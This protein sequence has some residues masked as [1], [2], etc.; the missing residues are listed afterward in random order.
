MSP[1]SSYRSRYS[2]LRLFL[3]SFL[4]VTTLSSL[5]L[6]A[7]AQGTTQTTT[8]TSA[9]GPIA[10]PVLPPPPAANLTGYQNVSYSASSILADGALYIYGG[11][12]K[13][14]DNPLVANIGSNQFLR[15]DLTKNFSTES[16]PWTPL[17]GS[18]TFTMIDSVPSYDGQ[19]M[20]LAGNRDNNGPLAHIY[21]LATKNWITTPN[22]PGMSSMTG[23]KRGNVGAALDPRS[24]L[25]YIYG[26]FAYLGF[27]NEISVLNTAKD[28]AN[29]DWTLSFNQSNVP[30]LYQPFVAYLPTQMKI[31]VFGGCNNYNMDTGLCGGCLPLSEG[32]L[33]DHG[34]KQATLGIQRTDLLN[35]P[36]PR[37]QSCYA[38]LKDGRVLLQGGRDPDTFFGDAWILDPANWTWTKL[39]ISGPAAAM[40]RA[41]HTCDMGPNGQLLIVG[42]FTKVNNISSYVMP[43]MAVIDTV[44]WTWKSDYTGA[45]VDSIWTTLP[46]NDPNEPEPNIPGTL[47]G[48]LPGTSSGLS[49]GA[50]A[51][52][53][54]GVATALLLVGLGVFYWR[55]KKQALSLT[56]DANNDQLANAKSGTEGACGPGLVLG[57]DNDQNIHID[58]LVAR[59]GRDN[60]NGSETNEK[61]SPVSTGPLSAATT[62]QQ[63]ADQY[64]KGTPKHA[65]G[66]VPID[67]A[68]LAAALLQAEDDATHTPRNATNYNS[69]SLNSPIAQ[70]R[71]PHTQYISASFDQLK[72]DL[73]IKPTTQFTYVSGPQSVPDSEALIER[74]SPGVPVHVIHARQVDQNGLYPP[75]TPARPHV[76]P[77]SVI[78]GGPVTYPIHSP[79]AQ[80]DG[81]Y[82][83][84]V[85]PRALS[86]SAAAN[87]AKA[88]TLG[89]STKA[90]AGTPDPR[91][92]QLPFRDPQMLRDLDDITRIIE[93]EQAPKSPHT[94]VPPVS[95]A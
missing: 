89:G 5:A 9:P 35:A 48:T 81:F 73:M 79:E 93:R 21:D 30:A 23:Y 66:T 20:I 34:E 95:W 46:Y 44:T 80:E 91:S 64:T 62:L 82:H 33:F 11:V 32:Y 60:G 59:G 13:F 38:V 26:G 77:S 83:P 70:H 10:T 75:L 22:L 63:Q 29:M 51:G 68:A 76:S 67:D 43:S 42:G 88:Q 37:Y 57:L 1:S 12:I 4:A 92:P 17:P 78:V 52:I 74:S 31:F 49:A 27:S 72:D 56:T 19:Q 50:K 28:A 85:G 45:P 71:Q 47:P 25:V 14:N 39:N 53:G 6:Q 24:G 40:T 3:L 41:G 87:E 36:L 8:P 2:L 16:P 69:S 15:L 94:I 84:G 55:R 65:K 54:A 86:F 18:L 58:G 7:Q 90:G 61:S